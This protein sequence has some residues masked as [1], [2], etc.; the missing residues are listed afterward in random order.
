MSKQD[1]MFDQKIDWQTRLSV[2]KSEKFD[3]LYPAQEAALNSYSSGCRASPARERIRDIT[4]ER[5]ALVKTSDIRWFAIISRQCE[6]PF[7]FI[8]RVR[9]HLVVKSRPLPSVQLCTA[10]EAFC[11]ARFTS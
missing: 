5:L 7:H 4:S 9:K 1:E 2:K 3:E 10:T 6:T 8:R 11:P